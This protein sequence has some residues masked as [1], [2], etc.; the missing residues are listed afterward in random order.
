MRHI[1]GARNPGDTQG[2]D[3]RACFFVRLSVLGVGVAWVGSAAWGQSVGTNDY[4]PKF[5]KKLSLTAQYEKSIPRDSVKGTGTRASV[6]SHQG[7]PTLHINGRPVYAMAMMPSPWGRDGGNEAIVHSCRD[8]AAAGVNL[9]SDIFG[10]N[11]AF[12][13]SRWWLDEGRYDFTIV[14]QR[15][16]A[17][18]E[19][20]PNAL[21]LMR[22]KLDTP[23]WWMDRHP[24]HRSHYLKDGKP[25]ASEGVS[26]A[27][28][29]WEASYG[30]MLRDYIRHV[31]AS[32]YADHV[33]GYHPAGGSAS[34][35]YWYGQDKGD[36]DYS[37][38]ARDRFRKWLKQKYGDDKALQT[39]WR[40]GDVTLD[41]AVFP[42]PATRRVAECLSFR[43]PREAAEYLDA[44]HFLTDMV[45]RNVIR[46]CTI[47]KE[48]TQ[49]RK[50]AGAFFGYST[51]RAGK[52]PKFGHL[53]NN[54]QHDLD[55]V[56]A[57]PAVDFLSTPVDYGQR[58]GGGEG[59][60]I[61]AQISSVHLHNKIFFD[62]ED[63]RTHLYSD[64]KAP[65]RAAT[66]AETLSVMQRGTGWSL[67]KGNA[68]WWF[69]LVG[70]ATFHQEDVMRNVS[71]L[72]K[73]GDQS[74]GGDKTPAGEIAFFA[75]EVSLN[76]LSH[77]N[78]PVVAASM[79]GS[80]GQ[81]ARMGAPFDLYALQDIATPGLPDYKAYVFLNSYYT[82]PALR[83]AV[84]AKVRKNNA[85]SV[86]L[87]AP[88][89]VTDNGFSEAAMRE[90][91]GI[92]LRHEVKKVSGAMELAD[93]GH[94][95]TAPVK[96]SPSFSAKEL[97]FETGPV[98]WADDPGAK[99][100]GT[101]GGKPAFVVKEEKGWRAVYSAFPL[102]K[103][104]LQGV[105]DYAGVHVYTRGYDVFFA[106]RGFAMLHASTGG[107]K[108]VLLPEPRRVTEL[109]TGKELGSRLSEI[110]VTVSESDTLIFRLDAAR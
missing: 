62:E 58:R 44:R 64:T 19:A 106:N 26:I 13:C 47:V 60:L 9:Y 37:P 94:P 105:C 41:S 93:G 55:G 46:S 35:W 12:A 103:E 81:M 51:L 28:E 65:C 89:F 74:L 97:S 76:Y 78:H 16:R 101:C 22:V 7:V 21:V 8:F 25:V 18:I 107:K 38:A 2:L 50:L 99:T 5:E 80:Y 70:N 48:E 45:T 72:K 14:D 104:L 54:G 34:E 53:G 77:T 52:N 4:D 11:P 79:W 30:R 90:L 39:A 27:S 86:W 56:L 1:K 82:T 59:N 24:D 31:E 49:G 100:L 87:Y 36:I 67:T 32:D 29:M 61:C 71:A 84:A 95:I 3:S 75:D 108:T 110:Q 6:K 20:N 10:G 73:I 33:F 91:T 92:A 23:K 15:M 68:L 88:G 17:F 40:R 69:L 66:L 96:K 109:I 63:L 102:T 43:D 42:T 83:Q 98:F 57:S 85:V